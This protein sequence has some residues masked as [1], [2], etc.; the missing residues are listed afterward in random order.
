MQMHMARVDNNLNK[1]NVRAKF[2]DVLK[3]RLEVTRKTFGQDFPSIV[4]HK[5]YVILRLVDA[6]ALLSQAHNPDDSPKIM[7]WLSSPRL[8]YISK[9]KYQN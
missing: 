4:R 8:C 7:E 5:H 2:A 1:L 6:M 9:L 3:N